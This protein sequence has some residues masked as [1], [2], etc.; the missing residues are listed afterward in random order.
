MKIITNTTIEKFKD[1]V[2]AWGGCESFEKGLNDLWIDY[3]QNLLSNPDLQSENAN[4]SLFL[5]KIMI[6]VFRSNS[7]KH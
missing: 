5:L 6:G 7:D 4:N 3:A 1:D 2:T